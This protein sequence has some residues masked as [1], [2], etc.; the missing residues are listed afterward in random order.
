L[1]FALLSPW[2]AW[3]STGKTRVTIIL[4]GEESLGEKKDPA[5]GSGVGD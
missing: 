4:Y 3:P 5:P 2:E 1:W